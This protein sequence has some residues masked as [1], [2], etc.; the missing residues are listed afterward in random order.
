MFA[1][2]VPFA[3][4]AGAM[5]SAAIFFGLAQLIGAS[6][7]VTPR[8]EARIIEFTRQIIDTPEVN[9]RDPQV[10]REPP[11]LRPGPLRISGGQE[12][13]VTLVEYTG[14]ALDPAIG[15]PGFPLRGVDGDVVPII[16]QD[17][18][19]PARALTG[20]VEGWVQVRFS[21][22]AVGSVRDAT[23]VASEPGTTFDEAALKAIARWRYNPRVVDGEAVERVGLQTVIRFELE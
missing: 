6:F 14:P 22:T 20:G 11:T 8:A 18:E 9:R 10:T 13:S 7:E 2:R 5:S 1:I 3:V 16:R 17:P 23:V 15:R 12:G 21:V 19:Y 4:V